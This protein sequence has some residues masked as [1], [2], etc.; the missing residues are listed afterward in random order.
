MCATNSLLQSLAGCS[1]G[2][3][4]CEHGLS[5]VRQSMPLRGDMR[6]CQTSYLPGGGWRNRGIWCCQQRKLTHRF[7]RC[8]WSAMRQRLRQN[9][10]FKYLMKL[11]ERDALREANKR[12]EHLIAELNHVV[13]GKQPEEL[14]EEQ[15]IDAPL[16]VWIALPTVSLCAKV[17]L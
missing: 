11:R 12:L 7:S 5:R 15:T 14:A 10:A 8:R 9:H 4:H 6:S 2:T 16:M 17:G 13:R 3:G 1:E